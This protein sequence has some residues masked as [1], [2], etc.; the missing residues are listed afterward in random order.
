MNDPQSWK[1]VK[2]MLVMKRSIAC[3][4]HTNPTLGEGGWG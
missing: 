3:G 4:L 2:S 1:L